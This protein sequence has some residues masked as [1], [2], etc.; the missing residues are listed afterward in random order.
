M[1]EGDSHE[2]KLLGPAEDLPL[3]WGVGEDINVQSSLAY[4]GGNGIEGMPVGFE[5]GGG[6]YELGLATNQSGVCSASWNT[7]E[8]G[9]SS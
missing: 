3:V 4:E 6:I 9:T 5:F 2:L 7:S 8:K 1:R